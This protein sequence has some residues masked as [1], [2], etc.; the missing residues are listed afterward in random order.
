MGEDGGGVVNNMQRVTRVRE[1]FLGGREAGRHSQ[2]LTLRGRRVTAIHALDLPTR[3]LCAVPPG[4][5][6]RRH[7]LGFAKRSTLVHSWPVIQKIL[8][9]GLT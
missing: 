5:N 4:P 8:Q 9:L 7:E 2:S 6:V 3:L 1:C